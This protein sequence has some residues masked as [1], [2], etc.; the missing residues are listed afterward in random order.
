MEITDKLIEVLTN[1]INKN[2]NKE[3]TTLHLLNMLKLSV[4]LH[5]QEVEAFDQ[6][7]DEALMDI[8]AS[9]CGDRD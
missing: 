5:N 8:R 6:L 4:K 3:L 9:Q 1:S 2:G 7:C